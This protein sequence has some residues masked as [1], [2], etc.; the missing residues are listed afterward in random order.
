MVVRLVTHCTL[1]HLNQHDLGSPRRSDQPVCGSYAFN[2]LAPVGQT[3][4]PSSRCLKCF[5]EV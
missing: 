4:S 5:W 2:R 1:K 3:C